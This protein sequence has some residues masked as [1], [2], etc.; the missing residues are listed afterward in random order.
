M[1]QQLPQASPELL[2]KCKAA[3]TSIQDYPHE[4]IL[5]R[6]ITSLLQNGPVFAELMHHIAERYKNV[7]FDA[8]AATESRGF[9]FGAPLAVL[10]QKP[11]VLIRK[12]GKLP[13]A[14]IKQE[15]VLEYGTDCLE[16]HSDAVS[17]G[18]KVLLI[19]DLLATGG[20]LEASV[21]LFQQIGGAVT[22]ACVV[23]NLP[24]L[25][26]AERLTKLGVEVY[27]VI[28]YPGH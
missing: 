12:K 11:L 7:D 26:G 16:I 6:D 3:I 22:H 10:L 4:G 17:A 28:D 2:E 23:I 8:I 21:K 18:Q 13:R 19:D 9:I 15:Y 27:S 5:F 24:D 14:T 1:S 25:Q 20:T